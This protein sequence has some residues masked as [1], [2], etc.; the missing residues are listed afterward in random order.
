QTQRE[1]QTQLDQARSR[2]QALQG[3]LASLETL[4]QAGLEKA[5]KTRNQWLKEH[6][7]DTAP[8][9]AEIL[10]VEAGWESAFETVLGEDLDAI[11]FKT[12]SPLTPLPQ[13]A[14]G[15]IP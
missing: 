8:R 4:Q 15:E 3:R 13:G 9:I 1:V 10:K 2:R 5:D 14:R 11:C 12:P 7:L 6:A